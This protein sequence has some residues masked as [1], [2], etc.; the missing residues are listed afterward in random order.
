MLEKVK[1]ERLDAPSRCLTRAWEETRSRLEGSELVTPLPDGA[2]GEHEGS[3]LPGPLLA[4]LKLAAM[5][6]V[7][8]H[9]VPTSRNGNL[10]ASG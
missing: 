8:S 1:E 10:V 3:S 6:S 4:L 9:A 7:G 5:V 2:G